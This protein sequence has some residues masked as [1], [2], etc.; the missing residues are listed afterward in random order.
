MCEM[1]LKG[2]KEALALFIFTYGTHVKG[3]KSGVCGFYA[4]SRKTLKI[5]CKDSYHF[6]S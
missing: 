2:L 1:M 6:Y 5:C 3:V 4:R